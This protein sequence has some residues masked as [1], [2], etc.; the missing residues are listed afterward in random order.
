MN[1]TQTN[2]TYIYGIIN[3][4]PLDLLKYKAKIQK[5]NLPVNEMEQILKGGKVN[6]FSL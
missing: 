2:K 6:T 1:E 3:I 4:I 5:Q